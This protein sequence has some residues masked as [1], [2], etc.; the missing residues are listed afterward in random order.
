VSPN[1]PIITVVA[2]LVI[3]FGVW[4]TTSVRRVR[5]SRGRFG[6]EFIRVAALTGRGA[7]EPAPRRARGPVLRPLKPSQRMGFSAQWRR[8]QSRFVNDPGAAVLEAD[9]LANEVL[10]ARGVPED[11]FERQAIALALEHP[12]VVENY[13]AAHAIAVRHRRGLASTEDLRKAM[14]HYRALFDDLLETALS[15]A[16]AVRR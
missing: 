6:P 9:L 10:R 1:A 16:G 11:E 5:T 15:I 12:L 3:G 14:I 7:A 13:R 2:I 8:E 4:V